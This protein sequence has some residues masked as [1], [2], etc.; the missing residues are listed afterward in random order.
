MIT[1]IFGKPR[2]G[3]TTYAVSIV[4]KNELK[5]KACKK[6]PLLK[7]ILKPYTA[8]YCTD[9]TIMGTIPITYENLGKW[10]PLPHSLILLEEA[11]IGLNNRNWKKLGDDATD[12]FCTCGHKKVDIIWS[13]QTA[14]VDCKL[15]SRTHYLWLAKPMPIIPH[16]SILTPIHFSIGVDN[17][18][19][20]LQDMYTQSEKLWK[21]VDVVTL[22][23]K[24]LYRK[25]YYKYFDSYVDTHIYTLDK[26]C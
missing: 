9:H 19:H 11:G 20:T 15:L 13:S 2:S 7:P 12:L 6:L 5:L 1:G 23:T 16:M 26:P 10:K 24:F 3:K 8:I 22:Q 4:R 14:D 25:P 18:R 17:E 21:L